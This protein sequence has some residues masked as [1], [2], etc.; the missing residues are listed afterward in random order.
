MEF[1]NIAS[2]I[3]LT[4]KFSYI[5]PATEIWFFL[6]YFWHFISP[7]SALGAPRVSLSVLGFS[8]CGL[9]LFSFVWSLVYPAAFG[10][11]KNALK[12]MC[13][14]VQKVFRFPHISPYLTQCHHCWDD[15]CNDERIVVKVAVKWCSHIWIGLLYTINRWMHK[16]TGFLFWETDQHPW[17]FSVTKEATVRYSHYE[18]K[19]AIAL[20]YFIYLFLL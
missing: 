10:V 6:L 8:S 7:Y 4:D 3:W 13:L 9:P 11:Q 18:K 15:G 16:C 5:C 14:R 1:K 2:F 12:L 19:A 20:F 17:V